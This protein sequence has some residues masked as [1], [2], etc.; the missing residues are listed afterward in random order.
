MA[1][2]KIITNTVSRKS[3]KH[4]GDDGHDCIV[5][6]DGL[7][8]FH[9]W[10][11][12]GDL[13]AFASVIFAP[14]LST[15]FIPEI[16]GFNFHSFANQSEF[17]DIQE[18]EENEHVITRQEFQDVLLGM[19]PAYN[20]I[21][22]D[23]DELDTAIDTYKA[24]VAAQAP[25]LANVFPPLVLAKILREQLPDWVTKHHVT[26]YLPCRFELDSTDHRSAFRWFLDFSPV[27]VEI[28]AID[29]E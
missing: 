1:T 15:I 5:S 3:Q 22:Y 13:F 19:F 12:D 4:M 14:E 8:R 10:H 25:V 9:H 18:M 26:A 11:E 21:L 6:S 27:S 2:I 16:F 29:E 17:Y 28:D 7:L 23:P 24:T 20:R